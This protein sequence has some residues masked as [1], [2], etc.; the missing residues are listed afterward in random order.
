MEAKNV[1]A[2]FKETGILE[3][4]GSLCLGRASA[5]LGEVKEITD[6]IKQIKYLYERYSGKNPHF[7]KIP[8]AWLVYCLENGKI[9][10][11]PLQEDWVISLLTYRA[12]FVG[13]NKLAFQ[14]LM[15][16]QQSIRPIADKTTPRYS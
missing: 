1:L 10:K 15:K 14:L 3:G 8:W 7:M 16:L 6:P 2:C 5:C 4:F 13:G 12:K 11:L 9:A